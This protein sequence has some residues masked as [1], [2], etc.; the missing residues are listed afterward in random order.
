MVIAQWCSRAFEMVYLSHC[1]KMRAVLT[2]SALF[3]SLICYTENLETDLAN[4]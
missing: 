1:M 2:L 3:D 4:L